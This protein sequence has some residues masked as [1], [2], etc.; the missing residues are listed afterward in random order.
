MNDAPI[1]DLQM[2]DGLK[3]Y[4]LGEILDRTASIYRKN[5]WLLAGISAIYAGAVLLLGLGQL[6]VQHIIR[7]KFGIHASFTAFGPVEIFFSALK[8]TLTAAPI[9]A[10]NLAIARIYMGEQ[11]TIRGAYKSVYSRWKNYISLML[12]LVVLIYGPY[13]VLISGIFVTLAYQGPF[14]GQQFNSDGSLSIFSIYAM[15]F[16]L[17]LPFVCTYM[18]WLSLRYA[19]SFPACV[20][21][22]LTPRVAMK[23]SLELTIGTRKRIFV[24]FLLVIVIQ[25]GLTLLLDGPI[26]YS[27]FEAAFKHGSPLSMTQKILQYFI[28]FFITTFV[29]PIYSTGFMLFYYDQRVRKEGF[30]IEWMMQAAGL[31][32]PMEEA[33][34]PVTLEPNSPVASVI[35]PAPANEAQQ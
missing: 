4:T 3:P 11:S 13:L 2:K 9:A 26:I 33:I 10:I 22:G 15:V 18:V 23:R 6:G 24:L 29:T 27:L 12:I 17:A 20:V 16:S 31:S 25:Y 21:E 28:L 35:S 32:V 34:T 19:L 7:V 14:A 1:N 30:D 5:F 8:W